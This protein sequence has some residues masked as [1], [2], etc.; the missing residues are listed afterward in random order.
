[1][2]FGFLA[3]SFGLRA[4]G[5]DKLKSLVVNATRFFILNVYICALSPR[6]QNNV[7]H[8]LGGSLPRALIELL[9]YPRLAARNP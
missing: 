3:S 7:R 9:A 6:L 5:F 1:M 2:G 4:S 8:L